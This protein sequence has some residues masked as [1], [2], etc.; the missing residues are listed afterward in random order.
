MS[1]EASTYGKQKLSEQDIL[2]DTQKSALKQ[3][4]YLRMRGKSLFNSLSSKCRKPRMKDKR[5]RRKPPKREN[6]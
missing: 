1:K 3:L 4:N 5:L 2:K 6:K